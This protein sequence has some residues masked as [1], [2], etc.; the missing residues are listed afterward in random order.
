MHWNATTL[1]AV[2]PN[3]ENEYNQAQDT[4]KKPK[5]S[6]VLKSDLRSRFKRFPLTFFSLALSP[7]RA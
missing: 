7:E 4:L 3:K 6:R 2:W 1:R 5:C